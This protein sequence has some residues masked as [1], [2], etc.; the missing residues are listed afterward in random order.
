MVTL[1]HSETA[2]W[3]CLNGTEASSFLCMRWFHR[4]KE[5]QCRVDHLAGTDIGK[6]STLVHERRRE[7]V[8][9]PEILR[10][11]PEVAEADVRTYRPEAHL[12]SVDCKTQQLVH[13]SKDIPRTWDPDPRPA[14]ASQTTE[15]SIR[16]Y[17]IDLFWINVFLV[18]VTLIGMFNGS[19]GEILV[20]WFSATIL[21]LVLLRTARWL[22]N[23]LFADAGAKPSLPD[24]FASDDEKYNY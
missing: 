1:Q 9:N 23:Q 13:D 17:Y 11:N 6:V 8:R 18:T 16:E 3:P 21:L 14:T 19:L 5:P 10:E 2:V 24:P 15:H 20:Y 4:T 12:R 7:R 22:R